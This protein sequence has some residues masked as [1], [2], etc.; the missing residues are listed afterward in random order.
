MDSVCMALRENEEHYHVEMQPLLVAL[1][2]ALDEERGCIETHIIAQAKAHGSQAIIGGSSK[3]AH[4]LKK[5]SDK[6]VEA[7]ASTRVVKNWVRDQ[8]WGHFIHTAEAIPHYGLIRVKW[9]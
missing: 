1:R 7:T 8:K 2:V 4:I 6:K 5:I 9:R 3:V